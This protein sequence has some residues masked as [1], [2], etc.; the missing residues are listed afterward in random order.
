MTPA[1]TLKEKKRAGEFAGGCF[2]L[3]G[4]RG[5]EV[6]LEVPLEFQK[7]APL[8]STT[9]NQDKTYSVPQVGQT[10]KWAD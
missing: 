6:S 5:K 9:Q 3:R 8:L 10:M 4:K 7:F 1:P 2:L